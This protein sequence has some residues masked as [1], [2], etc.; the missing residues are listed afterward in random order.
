MTAAEIVSEILANKPGF[1]PR[2]Y[3]IALQIKPGGYGDGDK[4]CGTSIPTL[5]KIAKKYFEI[6]LAE[7]ERLLQNPLHEARFVA[8]VILNRRFKSEPSAVL[9][10][11]LK[12]MRYVNNWDLVDCS[13]PHILGKYCLISGD[14][15]K[16][17]TL[18]DSDDL[19]ENRAAVVATLAFIRA[20]NYMPTLELCDKYINH[21]HHLIQKACGWMLR[22]V[23]KR[24]P[25][26]VVDFIRDHQSITSIMKSYALEWIRKK[27]RGS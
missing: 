18:S 25:E 23:S 17:W 6:P 11:Y 13:A 2:I 24:N 22:E 14:M 27:Q 8:L 3:M 5:R 20:D 19:W 16:I 10:A 15:E 7:C 26:I 1:V 4:I 9:K 12:N 21:D